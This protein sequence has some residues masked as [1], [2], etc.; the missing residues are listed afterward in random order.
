MVWVALV[1]LGSQGLRCGHTIHY[2]AVA[3]EPHNS[4]LDGSASCVSPWIHYGI[5]N[6][7]NNNKSSIRE[8]RENAPPSPSQWSWEPL[9]FPVRPE[10]QQTGSDCPPAWGWV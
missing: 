3:Y 10:V 8:P 9:Y 2:V 4:D 7:I 5:F 6:K 1:T